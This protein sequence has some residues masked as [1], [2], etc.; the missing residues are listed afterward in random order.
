M[1]KTDWKIQG[2]FSVQKSG[3][4]GE[5]YNGGKIKFLCGQRSYID[6]VWPQKVMLL[7]L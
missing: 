3:N 2:N 5:L 7:N 1:K 6:S 4:L